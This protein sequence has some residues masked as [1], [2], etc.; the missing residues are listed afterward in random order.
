V[1]W[2]SLKNIEFSQ[3]RKSNLFLDFFLDLGNPASNLE[4]QKMNMGNPVS[5][6]IGEA[7]FKP[8]S[9]LEV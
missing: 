1:I 9:N 3:N 2:I 5:N 4:A 6:P 7:D 8:A